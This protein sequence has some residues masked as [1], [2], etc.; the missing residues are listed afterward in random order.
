MEIRIVHRLVDKDGPYVYVVSNYEG[1]PVHIYVPL[2]I[3]ENEIKLSVN[4]K[5]VRLV[6]S[7]YDEKHNRY[8]LITELLVSSTRTAEQKQKLIEFVKQVMYYTNSYVITQ[9]NLEEQE[10]ELDI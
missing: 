6:V 9:I 2:N 10:L 3:S 5:G 4:Q 1:Y 8:I 7:Y